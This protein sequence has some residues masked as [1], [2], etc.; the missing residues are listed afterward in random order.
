MHDVLGEGRTRAVE[1]AELMRPASPA[2][3]AAWAKVYKRHLKGFIPCIGGNPKDVTHWSAALRY[4]NGGTVYFRLCDL[5]GSWE[6][7]PHRTVD[8]MTCLI[9]INNLV[10]LKE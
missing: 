8:C 6:P 7:A 9:R 3:K 10:I 4:W 2:E 5:V 1:G